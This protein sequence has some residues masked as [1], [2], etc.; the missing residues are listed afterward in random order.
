MLNRLRRRKMPP[1]PAV[2]SRR[3]VSSWETTAAASGAS[4]PVRPLAATMTTAA[5]QAAATNDTAVATTRCTIAKPTCTRS[6]RNGVSF[7][8]TILA[9][10]AR[11]SG[12][13]RFPGAFVQGEK[14]GHG[15]YSFAGGEVYE[16]EYQRG[17][18][19]GRGK[20]THATGDSYDG[21]W[22]DGKKHGIGTYTYAS[23]DVD[24]GCYEAD[25]DVGQGVRWSADRATAWEMQAGQPGREIPLDEA[26]EIAKRIGLPVPP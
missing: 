10:C 19:H 7:P 22:A 11:W 3:A 14:Q 9:Y 20:L 26:A 5:T 23:G 4:V 24:V 1:S 13:V 6:W 17:L 8:G 25:A 21:E 15:K 18:N 2:S 16:G 12:R